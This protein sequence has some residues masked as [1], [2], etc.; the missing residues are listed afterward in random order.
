MG[1]FIL[2]RKWR[3]CQQFS[4]SVGEA[5]HP[6]ITKYSAVAESEPA[7]STSKAGS[8]WSK[9]TRSA[10]VGEARPRGITT[11]GAATECSSQNLLLK[12][13][14]GTNTSQQL[15]IHERHRALDPAHLQTDVNLTKD[16]VYK[17]LKAQFDGHASCCKARDC[18]DAASN[19]DPHD[20]RLA[21]SRALNRI[22]E[23]F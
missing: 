10:A 8:T 11:S 12:L 3:T 23:T 1:A 19:V 22:R 20:L 9:T 6:G 5:R 17:T 18:M 13:G 14:L 7:E 15:G 21:V 4:K 16:F 2:S